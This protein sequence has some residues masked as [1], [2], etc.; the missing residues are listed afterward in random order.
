M[1]LCWL[2]IGR[3]M[4][5]M[6]LSMDR[7]MSSVC[8]CV[9]AGKSRVYFIIKYLYDSNGNATRGIMVEPNICIY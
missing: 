4:S 6:Y 1:S 7:K 9:G 3:K 5:V 2:N 8:V